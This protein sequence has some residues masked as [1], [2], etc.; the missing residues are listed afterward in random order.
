MKN[1]KMFCIANIKHT[2]FRVFFFVFCFFFFFFFSF[3]LFSFFVF[4]FFFA[5]SVCFV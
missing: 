5:L 3:F 1:T 4:V 2:L